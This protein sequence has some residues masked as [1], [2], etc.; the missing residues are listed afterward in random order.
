L[1]SGKS[2]TTGEKQLLAICRA[3]LRPK[4]IVI[5]DEATADIDIVTESKINKIIKEEFKD[6]TVISIAHRIHTVLGGDNIIVVENGKV[7]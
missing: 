3:A 5:L 4:K 1:D 2:L 6:C 7:V